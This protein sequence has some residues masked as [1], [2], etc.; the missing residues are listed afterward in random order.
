MADR[1]RMHLTVDVSAD[2]A[3]RLDEVV[4]LSGGTLDRTKA[5]SLALESGLP[6]LLET[7]AIE[8]ARRIT[9]C[10]R[11]GDAMHGAEANDVLL[12]GCGACGGIWLDNASAQLLVNQAPP[13]AVALV[14]R[15]MGATRPA[16]SASEPL[17][18]PLCADPMQQRH[19]ERTGVTVDVCAKHGTWYDHGELVVLLDQLLEQRKRQKERDEAILDAEIDL[20]IRQLNELYASGYRHGATFGATWGTGWL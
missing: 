20:E 11:C 3:K 16:V 18:C 12:K 5:A 4:Q 15:A 13:D 10:L 1:N 14:R 8:A 19:L 9:T 17:R 6:A 7:T 2:V